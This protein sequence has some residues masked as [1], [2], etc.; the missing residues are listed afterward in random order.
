MR[1]KK[2]ISVVHVVH[3]TRSGIVSLLKNMIPLLDSNKIL[4]SVIFFEH[5]N[6]TLKIFSNLCHSAYSL[7][8]SKSRTRALILYRNLILALSPDIIHSHSFQPG[9]W[10]RVLGSRL[11]IRYVC[12]VHSVYPYLSDPSIRSRMK[13]FLEATSIRLSRTKV[14]CVSYSV[15]SAL[16]PLLSNHPVTVIENGIPLDSVVNNKPD[17]Y[18]G[19]GHEFLRIITVGRLSYEKGYDI[20]LKAFAP[21][22]KE[23]P[24]LQLEILGAGDELAKLEALAAELNVRQ[25]VKFLGF[26]ENPF[27]FLVKADI[28]VCSSRYEGYP[29]SL[30]EAMAVGLP[31]VSTCVGGIPS[32][33]E[34]GDTGLLVRAENT[35]GLAKA[36]V[37][38]VKDAELRKRLGLNAKIFAKTRFDIMDTVRRYEETYQRVSNYN[39]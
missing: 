38:L 26:Q 32:M 27:A 36:I 18:R 29:L 10:A 30:A 24:N 9:L 13:R 2:K 39:G 35:E 15:R 3:W 11:G 12:T 23:F 33:L 14:V 19:D 21:I 25:K 28:Y 22:V 6:Q 34:D 17:I 7:H 37:R 31:V 4:T 16:Q 1:E 5:D 8:F 20:L